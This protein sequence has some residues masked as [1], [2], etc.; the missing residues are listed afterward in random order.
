MERWPEEKGVRWLVELLRRA[1]LLVDRITHLHSS[2]RE[3]LTQHACT[4]PHPLQEFHP[5]CPFQVYVYRFLTTGT[6]EEKI[7]Q[8][9]LSK[10]GLQQ[11]VDTSASA[12]SGASGNNLMS[13]E[14]LRDLFTYDEQTV[15][16]TYDAV[17]VREAKGAEEAAEKGEEGSSDGQGAQPEDVSEDLIDAQTSKPGALDAAAASDS[18]GHRPQRGQPP[19]EELERWAHHR[20]VDTVPDPALRESRVTEHVSFVFSVDVLGRDI[21][22]EAPLQEQPLGGM[23]VGGRGFRASAPKLDKENEP[24]GQALLGKDSTPA[25][26]ALPQLKRGLGLQ[27]R[28]LSLKKPS[29]I[30]P[31]ARMTTPQALDMTKLGVSSDSRSEQSSPASNIILHDDDDDEDDDDVAL[32]Q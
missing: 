17:C 31:P 15:S 24:P 9:Q 21:G 29:L 22:P 26:K 14:E 30:R 12:K 1:K 10:E 16:S 32:F 11:V 3:F 4:R 2:L 18:L 19:E 6:I 8:R 20:S 13:S 28:G 5:S 23:R 7:F 27:E 25:A